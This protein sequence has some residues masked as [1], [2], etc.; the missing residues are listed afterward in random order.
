MLRTAELMVYANAGLVKD[1]MEGLLDKSGDPMGYLSP[2][3][4]QSVR[5]SYLTGLA[6]GFGIVR[7]PGQRRPVELPTKLE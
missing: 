5:H 4:V 3:T 2:T 6:K 7:F 1:T